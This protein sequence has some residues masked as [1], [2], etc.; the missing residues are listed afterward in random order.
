MLVFEDLHWAD[1]GLLDFVDGLV[2]RATGVP[3]LVLCTRPAGAARAPP[4][5]GRWQGER[6]HALAVGRSPTRT[7]H[8]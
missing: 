8:A 7:P 3:L 2:D 4:R 6:G 5:L 1:D